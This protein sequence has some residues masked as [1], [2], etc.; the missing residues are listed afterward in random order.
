VRWSEGSPL[1]Q[2]YCGSLQHRR[3]AESGLVYM[4]AR[5][6]EP[7]TGRFLSEDPAMD[8]ANWYAYCDSDPINF[9]DPQRRAKID[10]GGIYWIEWQKHDGDLAW[11]EYRGRQPVQLG[12]YVRDGGGR[13]KHG[14]D[15]LFNNA[16]RKLLL[17]AKNPKVLRTLA[18]AGNIGLTASV[19]TSSLD[20]AFLS[21]PAAF[22]DLID[23]VGGQWDILGGFVTVEGTGL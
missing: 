23:Y 14:K 15:L 3:D 5:Y 11:G 18:K 12:Q 9:A 2:G 13:L 6:Y 4:R 17:N 10:I 21:D 7:W 19:L 16:V 20:G 22:A 8:G 1:D